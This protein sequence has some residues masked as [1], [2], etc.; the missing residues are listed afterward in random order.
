MEPDRNGAVWPKGLGSAQ[1]RYGS[2]VRVWKNAL[3]VPL[4]PPPPCIPAATWCKS[5][6]ARAEAAGR[7]A[8]RTRAAGRRSRPCRC[9]AGGCLPPGA[10]GNTATHLLRKVL[11]AG[12]TEGGN[13]PSAS[14][15]AGRLRLCKRTGQGAGGPGTQSKTQAD[16]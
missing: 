4:P 5:R 3:S 13:F 7:T 15:R 11:R 14:S 10:S 12:L 9:P 1:Y 2:P 6:F 8:A 16:R